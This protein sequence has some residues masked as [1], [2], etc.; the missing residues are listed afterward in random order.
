VRS[1]ADTVLASSSVVRVSVSEEHGKVRK[2]YSFAIDLPM[3][4]YRFLGLEDG[5]GRGN[6]TLSVLGSPADRK[7]LTV[8]HCKPATLARGPL[9]IF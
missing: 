1:F 4:L 8:V 7:Q 6:Y 9:L 5:R 3:R 2:S